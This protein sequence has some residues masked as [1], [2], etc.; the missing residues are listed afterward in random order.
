GT[1][2]QVYRVLTSP[3]PS[4][5]QVSQSTN[6]PNGSNGGGFF[7][8]ISSNG[9]SN[10]IIWALS[11]SGSSASG[12]IHLYAFNPDS[13]STL[14]PIY[15]G[16]AGTWKY[17]TGN[18][19]LVPVVA[20]G[21]VFVASYKLLNIFGLTGSGTTT[22]LNSNATPASYGQSVTLTAQVVSQGGGTPTGTVTFLNAKRVLG[23][24][25]LSG[26]V[27]TLT[28]AKL[29]LGSNS[30]TAEYSGDSNNRKSQATLT[31]QVVQA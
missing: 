5:N 14:E 18:S 11:R 7:T 8:S 15:N 17:P 4:L 29:P 22:T 6:V 27:A 12:N 2:V 23:T 26:G 9:T 24:V 30:L 20:H 21:E 13:G 25:P 10:A 28:T 16:S 1:N 31:Q 3:S 19:N